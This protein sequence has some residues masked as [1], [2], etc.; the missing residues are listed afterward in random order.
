[1]TTTLL[2]ALGCSY[3]VGQTVTLKVAANDYDPLAGSGAVM[4]KPIPCAVFCL[5]MMFIGI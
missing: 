1:M 2:D 5:P 3:D 4:E